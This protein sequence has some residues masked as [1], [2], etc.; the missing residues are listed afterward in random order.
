MVWRFVEW[1][2]K[3]DEIVGKQIGDDDDGIRK[4][5]WLLVQR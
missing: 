2:S 5:G 3:D 4:K 1:E